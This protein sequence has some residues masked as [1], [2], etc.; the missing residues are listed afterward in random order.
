MTLLIVALMLV[1]V[2]GLI[3]VLGG[4]LGAVQTC[5]ISTRELPNVAADIGT[6]DSNASDLNASDL[7]LSGRDRARR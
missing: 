1:V 7:N 4:H 6:P 3:V 2:F 5:T